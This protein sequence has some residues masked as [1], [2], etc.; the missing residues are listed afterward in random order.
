MKKLKLEEEVKSDL[1]DVKQCLQ[2]LE[3]CS[4]IEDETKRAFECTRV[5]HTLLH[6]KRERDSQE[7]E[8]S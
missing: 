8:E 2:H 3:K 4:M 7:V 1:I 6:R 5:L